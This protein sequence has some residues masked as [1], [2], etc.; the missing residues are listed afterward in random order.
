MNENVR[1]EIEILK[2]DKKV[3]EQKLQREEQCRQ[4][5]KVENEKEKTKV[6]LKVAKIQDENQEL[7]KINKESSTAILDLRKRLAKEKKKNF[8]LAKQLKSKEAI[9][10]EEDSMKLLEAGLMTQEVP[11]IDVNNCEVDNSDQIVM[12]HSV[13]FPKSK[14]SE[15]GKVIQFLQSKGDLA[16]I[17]KIKLANLLEQEKC[18]SGL[19]LSETKMLCDQDVQDKKRKR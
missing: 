19:K 14:L 4:Q 11:F 2:N 12:K 6:R 13:K 1:H 3:L 7:R 17:E 9:L 15:R 10:D 5:E 18:L 16:E 8:D